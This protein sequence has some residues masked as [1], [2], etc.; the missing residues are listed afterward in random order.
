METQLLPETPLRELSRPE[1]APRILYIE[2][3]V[4]AAELFK[5]RMEKD[6]YLVDLAHTGQDGIRRFGERRYDLVALDY[7]L[8]EMT[9]LVVLRAIVGSEEH[10]PAIM[11]TSDDDAAVVVEALRLG[12]SDYVIKSSDEAY[13]QQLPVVAKRIIQQHRGQREYAQFVDELH[14][15]NRKLALLNRA[16]QIFSSTLDEAQIALQLVSSICEFTDTEGSSVWLWADEV[17]GKLECVA[18]FSQ[19]EHVE[20]HHVQL[21]PGQGIAGW[22]AQTEQTL[23]VNDAPLDP[24]FSNTSDEKLNFRTQ[25]LLAVPLRAPDKT[26][27]VLELVN[28]RSGHFSEGDRILAETLAASAAIAIEN[29]RFVQDLNRQTEELRLRNEELDAFAHTVAH[30]LKTPLSLVTGYADMLRENFDVLHPDEISMYL[31]QLIDNSMRMNH[32]IESLL[33]LAG[34][35]GAS[36]V[37]IEPLQMHEVVM[38]AMNRVEFM[39]AERE[40]IVHIPDDWP[41]AMGYGPWLEEVWYN[42]VIN[43]LKYGGTPPELRLGHDE[44]NGGQIRFWIEDNGPGVPAD[45][46]IL[47]KPTIRAQR[48]NE[49][50]GYGLGLSIVK[51]IVERLQGVVGAENVPDGGSRFYFTLPV[52]PPEESSTA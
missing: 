18:I 21:A 42:Y 46:A 41:E 2:D 52:A 49:R 27:G 45:S 12:I 8:P 25:S 38:E 47:F 24:R 11:V 35:R 31:N 26:L 7:Q 44:P 50:R 33:L 10:P 39:L 48:S 36:H 1:R 19:G 13:L 34:V 20:P 16:T 22:A 30:D 15:Q 6:G 51:R 29:A 37:E 43:A 40:A 4:V 32:I 28:K 17:T 3:D 9:G 5:T 23:V 14:D